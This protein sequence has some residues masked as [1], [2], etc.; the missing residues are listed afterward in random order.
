M[1]KTYNIIEKHSSISI[2]AVRS[3]S[4]SLVVI[5]E[6]VAECKLTSIG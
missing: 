4:G 6:L 5:K 1:H 2:G 3:R